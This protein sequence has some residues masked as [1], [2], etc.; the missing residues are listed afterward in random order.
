MSLVHSSEIPSTLK[1]LLFVA[2]NCEKYKN[3]NIIAVDRKLVEDLYEELT[4]SDFEITKRLLS[5]YK[6]NITELEQG[7]H[8]IEVV[9]TNMD[10]LF[11]EDGSI[12]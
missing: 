12:F 7:G 8:K 9:G 5:K 1:Y 3:N 2:N 6:I 10:F 4:I 11:H